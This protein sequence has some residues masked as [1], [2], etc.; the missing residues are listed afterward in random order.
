MHGGAGNDRL[1]G[2]EGRD[3]ALYTYAAPEGLD[4][5]LSAGNFGGVNVD[6]EAGT[7]TGSFG[8]DRL[9]SIEDVQG[10]AGADRLSG[11]AFDNLLA[12]EAGDDDL[13]GL[14]GNDILILG[15]G[16]D[17]ADGGL[18]N[19]RILTGIGVKDIDG[20]VGEDRLI[21]GSES[22]KITVI[23]NPILSDVKT[24][25]IGIRNPA[26]INPKDG[27]VNLEDDGLP[28]CAEMWAN[29]LRLTD[30]DQRGGWAAIARANVKMADLANVSL[31]GNMSTPGF[32]SIEKKVS[33]RQREELRGIDGRPRG[34]AKS[35]FRRLS[36]GHSPSR[37][38]DRIIV[39]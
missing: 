3:T 26:R 4:G 1:D 35:T 27:T 39:S 6:L 34:E 11:D 15:S 8:E 22:G 29:E 33:E 7:A 9:I 24:I 16:N 38:S 14:G 20:G 10:S 31:A 32:G 28:K 2:G 23:G 36:R 25:M 13:I 18:G 12:G 21:F 37:V 19:D 17:T 30:F 5:E